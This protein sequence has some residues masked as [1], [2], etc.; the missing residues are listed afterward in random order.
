VGII[1]LLYANANMFAIDLTAFSCGADE[2]I[3]AVK[4]LSLSSKIRPR[5]K[6]FP[7]W[8]YLV[9]GT[10]KAPAVGDQESTEGRLLVFDGPETNQLHVI[11]TV[12][13]PGCVYS[14]AD[15]D[16]RVVAAV[17]TCVCRQS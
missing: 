12:T 15:S 1:D 6:Q 16:G 2:E 5:S 13:V 14:L 8:T 11:A 7:R 9:I 10:A 17:N 3:T 4:A